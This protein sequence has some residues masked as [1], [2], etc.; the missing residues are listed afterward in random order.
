[1]SNIPVLLPTV[2]M[3][4]YSYVPGKFP[5]PIRDP[6]G[7]SFGEARGEIVNFDPRRWRSCDAYVRGIDL[8]NHG[9]YWESHEAWEA[10]WNAAGREGTIA[11]F[12][13]GLIKLAAACV[14]AREGSA[15]GVARHA[16]RARRLFDMLQPTSPR[17]M[18]LSTEELK[19]IAQKLVDGA[20]SFIN[21]RDDPVVRVHDLLLTPK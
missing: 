8:F 11:D 13:K 17:L 12:T 21:K 5:H 4:E 7:H 20:E 1:M 6:N 16:T 14:K 19:N 10:V 2:P 9:F 3:P 15:I 18:G